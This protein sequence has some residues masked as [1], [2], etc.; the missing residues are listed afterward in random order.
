MRAETIVVRVKTVR[1]TAEKVWKEGGDCWVL[2]DQ[3]K[4]VESAEKF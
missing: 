4:V 3:K 1:G 2:K